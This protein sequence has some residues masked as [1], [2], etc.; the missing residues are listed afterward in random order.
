[1]DREFALPANGSF[2]F[3]GRT[4]LV[5]GAARG[6]GEAVAREI[7]LGGGRV[8]VSDV[9]PKAAEAVARDLDPSGETAFA[10]SLDVREKSDFE[11]ALVALVGKWGGVDIVVNNAGYAKRTPTQDI[12]PEEFDQI[13]AINMRSVFLSCQLFSE[14]MKARGYGRIVNITSLAGQ[15]GGTVA[16]PHYAASKAGAIMLSKYFAR[17]L[18]GSGVTVNAVSPGPIATAKGRLS[19]EQIARVESEVP[20][21]RFM[22]VSEIAA[23]T[24]LLASDRGGF[25]VG[26]TLDMN[27]GLYLR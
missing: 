10:L 15:N 13:V 23:A 8:A 18:A 22:E 3:V 21:G 7:H 14:H 24:A 9:D 27:G 25:F 12:S 17:Y 2:S 5:T 1:M 16:S 11:A 19:P 20:I 6:V 4:A 26:A